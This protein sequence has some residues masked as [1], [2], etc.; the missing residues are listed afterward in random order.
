MSFQTLPITMS[1]GP[2]VAD[3]SAL[4][5]NQLGELISRQLAGAVRA[6]VSFYLEVLFDPTSFATN[7]IYNS[8]QQVWKAWNQNTGTYVPLQTF[9]LG[10]VKNTYVGTDQLSVGWVILNGRALT[11]VPGI[12][13]AQLNVLKDFFGTAPGTLLPNVTP[14]NLGG[15]PGS[16]LFS[17]IPKAIVDPADGVI[18]A[19]PIGAGYSQ[20]EV[21]ALRDNTEILR[22]STEEVENQVSGVQDACDDLLQALRTPNNPPL[23]AA[24]FVGYA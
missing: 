7:L 19:L 24:I 3:V 4:N 10:D 22:D 2:V 9:Q 1:W 20:S 21:E 18:G 6:D 11:A 17:D 14:M 15:L 23:Y 8:T 12:T 5:I 13:T 16:A